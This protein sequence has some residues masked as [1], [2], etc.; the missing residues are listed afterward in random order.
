MEYTD[1]FRAA[2]ALLGE[3][4]LGGERAYGLGR[5]TVQLVQADAAWNFLADGE[6]PRV[7]TLALFCPP[8][9]DLDLID[10]TCS[11]GLIERKGWIHSPFTY[12][13]LK[14]KTVVM[15]TAGSVFSH[16]LQGQVLDV[17]PVAWDVAGSHPIYRF[18]LPFFVH[19]R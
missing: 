12:R 11:Y 16:P 17:T 9:L 6:G 18:G 19:T 4:G 2:L 7:L 8:E 15:F 3:L 5:F 10:E 13:Q 14:R 1:D